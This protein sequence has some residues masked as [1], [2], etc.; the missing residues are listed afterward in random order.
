MT[1]FVCLGIAGLITGMAF[2]SYAL[3][4][5]CLALAAASFFSAFTAGLWYSSMILALGLVVLQ[6][7]YLIGLYSTAFY[8]AD[9]AR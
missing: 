2:N 6:T 5:S 9:S 4:A 7:G 1:I 3:L 8:S